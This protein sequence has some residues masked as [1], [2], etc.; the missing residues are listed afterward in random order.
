ME[1]Y[2]TIIGSRTTPPAILELM[3][4]YAEIS[5]KQGFIIRSGGAAGADHIVTKYVPAPYREIYIPWNDF[6]GLRH[7]GTDI[8]LWTKSPKKVNAT[9]TAIE[10]YHNKEFLK[11][12]HKA[13][14]SRNMMQIFGFNMD[15][16]EKSEAVICWTPN[17][18]LIG[19]TRSAIVAANKVDIPVY[20]LGD[21]TTLKVIIQSIRDLKEE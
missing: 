6:N 2:I 7:N 13:L 4:Q 17:G 5:Y 15:V 8:F 16:N 12:S 3:R 20:N 21:I 1:Q 19:G 14:H 10:C 9:A 11:P 18:E